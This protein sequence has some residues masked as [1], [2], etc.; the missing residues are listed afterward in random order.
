MWVMRNLF[1]LAACVLAVTLGAHVSF[2]LPGAEVPQTSQTLAVL[3]VGAWAGPG[4]GSAAL[5]LYLVLGAS[6]LPL[7][8]GGAAG[9]DVLAGRGGGFLAAFVPAAALAGWAS[10]RHCPTA[11]RPAGHLGAWLLL[12]HGVILL[13]GWA[14][15]SVHIGPAASFQGGVAPFLA[16]AFVKSAAALSALVL[17]AG[18]RERYRAADRVASASDQRPVQ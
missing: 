2:P 10:A 1:V 8:A 6:G 5:A 11:L 14:W 9:L 17:S 3:L 13:V 18:L 4:R 16:G 7:F 15:L 12:A